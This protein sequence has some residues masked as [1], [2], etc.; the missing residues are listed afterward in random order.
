MN[1]PRRKGRRARAGAASPEEIHSGRRGDGPAERAPARGRTVREGRPETAICKIAEAGQMC[2]RSSR[3]RED[4]ARQGAKHAS[5]SQSRERSRTL[6]RPRARRGGFVSSSL[7]GLRLAVRRR[8]RRHDRKF[9]RQGEGRQRHRHRASGVRQHQFEQRRNRQDADIRTRPKPTNAS[10][11]RSS[12]PTRLR[13]P[14]STSR[15]RTAPRSIFTTSPPTIS[16]PARSGDLGFAAM[17]ASGNRQRRRVLAQVRRASPGGPGSRRRPEGGRR[18]A[19]GR[20]ERA[21][22]PPDLAVA[23]HRRP[24]RRERA[25]ARRSTSRSPRPRFAPATTATPSSTATP[26]SPGSSSSRRPTRSSARTSPNSAIPSSRWR[27]S[28]APTTS[29]PPRSSRSTN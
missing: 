17:E 4:V 19:G 21:P 20:S 8:R 25:R 18:A 16:T 23:G 14:R 12:R 29:P 2:G 6:D 3:R 24:G 7:H 10:W 22:G 11:R 15:A 9:H 13:S 5:S 28:S 1:S 27:W 26:N